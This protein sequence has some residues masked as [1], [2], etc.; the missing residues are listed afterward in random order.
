MP[1]YG[2]RSREEWGELS[3]GYFAERTQL[4]RIFLLLDP[5]AGLKSTDCQLMNHLDESALSYQVVLT[6]CDKLSPKAFSE[7]KA[8]IEKYLVKNAICCYPHILAVGKRRKSQKNE[9]QVERELSMIRWSILSA[10][11]IPLK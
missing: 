10:A 11:G 5:T 4:K 6:K 7:S 2:F 8:A 9:D 3:M 1:G